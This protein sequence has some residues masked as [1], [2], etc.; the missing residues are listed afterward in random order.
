VVFKYTNDAF[1]ERKDILQA[2]DVERSIVYFRRMRRGRKCCR[3]VVSQT[4][5][6][7]NH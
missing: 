1:S 5:S 7:V 6:P 2:S 4:I 3:N